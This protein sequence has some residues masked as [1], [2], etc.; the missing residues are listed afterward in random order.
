MF[1]TKAWV[2]SRMR[3]AAFFFCGIYAC[4]CDLAPV[5]KI[6]SLLCLV[7]IFYAIFL[8]VF[9]SK[10]TP[11]CVEGKSFIKWYGL[12]A[13]FVCV[14]AMWSPNSLNYSPLDTVNTVFV[15]KRMFNALLLTFLYF[16]LRPTSE[17]FVNVLHGLLC[18]AFIACVIVLISERHLI[19]ISRLG[20]FSYG[21]GPTFGSVASL[22]VALS[23]FFVQC[24]MKFFKLY[25]LA[26]FFFLF[27]IAVSA[28]RQPLACAL[29]YILVISVLK[30]KISILKLFKYGL[31]CAALT[32]FVSFM[33]LKIDF[34]YDIIGYRVE[35]FFEG[36]DGSNVERE[37]MRSFAM[38][39]FMANHICG[40]GIHG[41]AVLFGKYYGW[42]VWSHCGFTEILSCY[43]IIGFVLFYRYF[44][45]GLKK[46]LFM[47]QM[48]RLYGA[49]F[50]AFLLNTFLFDCFYVVYLDVRTIFI[51]GIILKP[52]L[53]RVH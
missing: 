42:S 20:T 51:L 28:S 47:L 17:E 37:I 13:F 52:Y 33:I 24:Q 43:G 18:G 53:E 19:G 30:Q 7:P 10:R 2:M 27:A 1:P 38:S 36:N 25:Y 29:I 22:G 48:N 6:V 40:V 39:L 11:F 21:A 49:L 35:Q 14:S 23:F 32:L 15:Y 16:Q 50:I 34:L 45:L 31:I 8:S 26:L 41:F 12:F 5:P 9:S 4:I 3:T 44:L 46:A